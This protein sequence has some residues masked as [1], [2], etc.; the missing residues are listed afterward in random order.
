MCKCRS[1][2][3]RLLARSALQVG[4][5]LIGKVHRQAIS[6][7]LDDLVHQRFVGNAPGAD[8]ESLG[9]QTMYQLWRQLPSEPDPKPE[10]ASSWCN[11]SSVLLATGPEPLVV[12]S[13]V[14]S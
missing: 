10:P 13:T 5:E 14:S 7:R 3:L 2:N 6:T 1:R 4:Q 11:S 9:V 8:D 12:R